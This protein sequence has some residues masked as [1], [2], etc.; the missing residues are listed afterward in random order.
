MSEPQPIRILVCLTRCWP[1]QFDE[2]PTPPSPH[3]WA[4]PAAPEH[5]A[6]TGQPEPTGNCGCHCAQP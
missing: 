2:C 6:H 3:P 5:A 1:C 4:D